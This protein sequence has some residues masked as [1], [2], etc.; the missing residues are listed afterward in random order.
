M[1]HNHNTYY[2]VRLFPE[3]FF[4]KIVW[5]LLSRLTTVVWPA[6]PTPPLLVIML[7]NNW[8]RGSGS[9]WPDYSVL[10]LVSCYFK[11]V[12]SCNLYLNDVMY[13]DLHNVI[14]TVY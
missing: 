14:T 1:D 13:I 3:L 10:Y 6:R 12:S 7:H 9:N 8:E 2:S 4:Q 5:S 11:V